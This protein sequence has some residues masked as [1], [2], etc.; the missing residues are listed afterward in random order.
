MVRSRID[1]DTYRSFLRKDV[2]N[3]IYKDFIKRDWIL[4][5]SPSAFESLDKMISQHKELICKPLDSHCGKGVIKVTEDN[6]QIIKDEVSNGARYLCEQCIYNCPELK[7]PNPSS[8]NTIRVNTFVDKTGKAKVIDMVLRVGA[9]GSV[10]DNLYHGGVCYPINNC[11]MITTYGMNT[12]HE[13]Y[14]FH[15][16]TNFKMIGFEI[17]RYKEIVK[18][19]ESIAERNPKAKFVGW[20]IAITENSFDLIEGNLASSE[21]ATQLYGIGTY[22]FMKKN[23]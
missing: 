15:P 11:G 12:K 16:G 19:V 22:Q 7:Q 2:F 21:D 4:L 14:Y 6:L 8:L 9:W 1:F 5:E 20:D 17:P 18:Y 10:V 13:R 23:W 3:D